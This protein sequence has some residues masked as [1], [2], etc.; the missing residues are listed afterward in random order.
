MF[1]GWAEY[2][3]YGAGSW[4]AGLSRQHQAAR[5]AHATTSTGPAF[6]IHLHQE[7]GGCTLLP[8]ACALQK[9]CISPSPYGTSV[10]LQNS[11][12]EFFPGP[13]D[14]HGLVLFLAYLKCLLPISGCDLGPSVAMSTSAQ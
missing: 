4:S 5:P 13:P 1:P 12:N 11:R 7:E 3:H 10:Y 6:T 14:I 2:S 8:P 9:A